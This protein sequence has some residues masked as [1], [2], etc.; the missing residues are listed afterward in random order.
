MTANV[1]GIS[2]ACVLIPGHSCATK[3]PY[4]ISPQPKMTD[5]QQ[6]P[7]TLLP[8]HGCVPVLVLLCVSFFVEGYRL[9]HKSVR[10]RETDRQADRQT[11][12]V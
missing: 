4:H 1:E 12:D 5:M 9:S 3:Q 2:F 6:V 7:A 11:N 8:S 10:N